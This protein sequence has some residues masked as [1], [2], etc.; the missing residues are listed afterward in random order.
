MDE[1]PDSPD[2]E[3]PLLEHTVDMEG[4]ETTRSL[5]RARSGTPRRILT[6]RSQPPA[7]GGTATAAASLSRQQTAVRNCYIISYLTSLHSWLN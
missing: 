7:N 6:V 2:A 1:F 3:E 4:L 5:N